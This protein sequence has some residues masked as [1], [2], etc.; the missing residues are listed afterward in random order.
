MHFPTQMSIVD[1]SKFATNTSHPFKDTMLCVGTKEGR[2]LIYNVETVENC[3]CVAKTKAG[4]M[5]GEI[6]SLS[7]QPSGQLLLASSSS[8]EVA[9]FNIL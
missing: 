2:V 6:R 7:V 1:C 3:Q 5:F 8:G 9:S 4:V